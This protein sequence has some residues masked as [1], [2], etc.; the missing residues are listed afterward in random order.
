MFKISVRG[1]SRKVVFTEISSSSCEEK[2]QKKFVS[3]ELFLRKSSVPNGCEVRFVR[4]TIVS[5]IDNCSRSH[6]SPHLNTLVRRDFSRFSSRSSPF[7]PPVSFELQ[8]RISTSNRSTNVVNSIFESVVRTTRRK[9]S[10]VRGICWHCKRRR[11]LFHFATNSIYHFDHQ[12]IDRVGIGIHVDERN[13]GE[14]HQHFLKADRVSR[15]RPIETKRHSPAEELEPEHNEIRSQVKECKSALR[16]CLEGILKEKF[17]CTPSTFDDDAP[18]SFS[19]S[20]QTSSRQIP[21]SYSAST[22]KKHERMS[23]DSSIRIRSF[24]F[25]YNRMWVAKLSTIVPVEKSNQS[26]CFNLNRG[27]SSRK[28]ENRRL[29]ARTNVEWR[30]KDPFSRRRWTNYRNWCASCTKFPRDPERTDRSTWTRTTFSFCRRR[31]SRF[32]F[33]ERL[34]DF[35]DSG[36][37][38]AQT[39]R[40]SRRR[41]RRLKVEIVDLKRFFLSGR[42]EFSEETT[43]SRDFSTSLERTTRKILRWSDCFCP[44]D[45]GEETNEWEN[46]KKKFT[47]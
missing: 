45:V 4:L 14:V 35:V 11:T 27:W 20:R 30:C 8:R 28:R 44:I 46:W 47:K 36:Q 24:A 43:N 34:I 38:F 6:E 7:S 15:V 42:V 32:Y 29:T 40:R 22:S 19:L 5:D 13:E 23:V 21:R 25:R 17:S 18:R 9:F 33:V 31:N 37:R 10:I 12:L 26:I 16:R 1:I 2:R 3:I 39:R 41:T